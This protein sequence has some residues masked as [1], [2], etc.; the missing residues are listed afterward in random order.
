VVTNKTMKMVAAGRE[1]LY[2]Y[3]SK[4]ESLLLAMV[5]ADSGAQMEA[6]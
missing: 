4:V 1:G 5:I 3:N 2:R 6:G